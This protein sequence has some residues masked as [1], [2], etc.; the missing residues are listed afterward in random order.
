MFFIIII[1]CIII[2]FSFLQKDIN[3]NA[4]RCFKKMQGQWQAQNVRLIIL[5]ID[6]SK[7]AKSMGTECESVENVRHGIKGYA[8]RCGPKP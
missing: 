3:H 4:N 2:Y 8:V 5:Q 6:V 1:I 7:N